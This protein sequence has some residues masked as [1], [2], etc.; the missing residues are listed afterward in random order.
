M[1]TKFD[2]SSNL[3]FNKLIINGDTIMICKLDTVVAN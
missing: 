1:K 3:D 2:G